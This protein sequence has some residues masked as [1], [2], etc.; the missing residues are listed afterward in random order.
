M[1]ICEIWGPHSG[2]AEDKG[3]LGYYAGVLIN[4]TVNFRVTQF[5]K[6]D[7]VCL[8]LQTKAL[9]LLERSVTI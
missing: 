2:V 6:S 1:P 8:I 4:N 9:R 3:V 5:E 7:L